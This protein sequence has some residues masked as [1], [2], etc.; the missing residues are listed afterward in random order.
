MRQGKVVND[1]KVPGPVGTEVLVFLYYRKSPSPAVTSRGMQISLDYFFI[2]L[3]A[4]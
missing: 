2:A 4:L 3:S 1:K